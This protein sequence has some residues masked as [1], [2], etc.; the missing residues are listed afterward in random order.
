MIGRPPEQTRVLLLAPTAKDASVSQIILEDNGFNCLVCNGADQMIDLTKEGAGAIVLPEAAILG[1]RG[2]DLARAL[3]SQPRWSSVPLIVLTTASGDYGAKI[4]AIMEFGDVTLLKRPLEVQTFVNAVRAALRNR[5]RQYQVKD[6]VVEL[7][8]AHQTL[9]SLT[10]DLRNADRKK[11]HYIALLAHEL[12]NPLAPLRNGLQVIRLAEGDP[13]AVAEVREM[14]DRQLTHMIRLVDD[15][16]D[17][18]RIS[19]NKMELRRQRLLLVDVVKAAVETARPMIDAAGHELQIHLPSERV[20]LDG[21]S[22]RLS[23]VFSNLLTNSAKYTKPSGLIC[24]AAECEGTEVV[25]T[26]RDNGIGI[27]ADS[28][29]SIFDMFSQVDR[30]IER[31]TGGLGIGL[32]LVKGLVELH[33]GSVTADSEGPGKGSVFMVRLP[34]AKSGGQHQNGDDRGMKHASR[35]VLVVDDNHDSAISMA[36]MLRLMG[37]KVGTAHDGI[38][39]V[40]QA[41]ALRPEIILMDIGM[42]RLNGLE[43]TRRIRQEDWGKG[44]RII[45]LTGWGQEGDKNQSREAGCDGHLVKPVNLVD[46]EKVLADVSR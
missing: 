6:Y 38:E 3:A 19:C 35:R 37:D 22:T 5:E 15:L 14:M 34:L 33:G 46:L 45:A 9:A 31:S 41:K 21:D 26:V 16:L 40:E 28:L 10:E 42:P 17:V 24:L 12:R 7:Q 39:A 13:A 27:P 30:P 32:A 8:K 1:D 43:A 4:E 20:L 29:A 18:S 36:M 2:P 23:Q 11:S 44:I 25:V